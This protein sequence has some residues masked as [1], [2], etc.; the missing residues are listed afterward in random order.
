MSYR[1]ILVH[2]ADERRLTNVLGPAIAVARRCEAHL[3]ALS[4]LPPVIVDPALTPGGI[5]TIIDGHRKAYAR[6]RDRMRVAF[7]DAIRA[8]GISA[9]WVNADAER[10]TVWSKVVEQGRSADLIVALQADREWSYSD[11]VEAPAEIVLHAGRPVLFVPNVG[12]HADFGRRVLVAWNG[13]RES[14]RAANDAIPLL[15]SAEKVSVLWINPEQDTAAQD[16]PGAD[17]CAALARHGIK[18][19]ADAVDRP[20][21]SAG[22]T[23]LARIRHTHADLL[24][25]GCYGH[26]RLRE[27]ILGGATKTVLKEMSVPVLMS[28]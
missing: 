8:A 11:L 19:E 21:Q 4:V 6:E 23:L 15:K 1:T 20:D 16:L 9:A 25:M 10:G 7:E 26:S 5:I 14:A 22:E 17:L 12:N 2:C 27:F 28:H 18:C 13:R 3:T 24:V